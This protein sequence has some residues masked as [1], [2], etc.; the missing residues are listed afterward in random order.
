MKIQLFFGL[1]ILSASLLVSSAAAQ[2][3][4]ILSYGSEIEVQK[5]GEL[6]ITEKI[7]VNCQQVDIKRGIYRDFPT[8]YQDGSGHTISVD[9]KVLSV[10]RD[11]QSEKWHTESI[12][13]G[14][15]VYIGDAKVYLA[16]GIYS[17]EL[18]FKTNRQLGYFAD[19]DELYFNTVGTGWIFPIRYAYARITLPTEIKI[20]DYKAFTGPQEVRGSNYSAR[21]LASNIIQFETT[22]PLRAHEGLT[23][24]VSWPKGNISQSSPASPVF[25]GVAFALLLVIVLA[26]YYLVVWRKVGRDPKKGT[27]IP[28]YEAPEQ[29]EPAAVKYIMSM[30]YHNKCLLAAIS[31]LA[32]KGFIEISEHTEAKLGGLFDQTNILL[33]RKEGELSK[34]SDVENMIWT[35]LFANQDMIILKPS[36]E[37]HRIFYSVRRILKNTLRDNYKEKI[38]ALNY[39]YVIPPTIAALGLVGL[40]FALQSDSLPVVLALFLPLGAA[41]T[42]LFLYLLKTPTVEGRALMD[43]I[44][45][46]KMYLATAE[47]QD[48]A[49]AKA[50]NITTEMFEK[51]LPYAVALDVA[52]NWTKKFEASLIAQGKDFSHYH[53]GWHIGN[54]IWSSADFVDKAIGVNLSNAI[55][56]AGNAP[57]RSSGSGGSSGGG[58]G[59]GGGG[60]W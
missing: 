42:A 57:G 45:G 25:E 59:G 26:I 24:F 4:E 21:L 16:K 37:N 31:Q 52:S 56:A 5:N 3:E 46:Y 36:N 43:H 49:L 44:E 12:S 38:F 11:G 50:E 13:N 33:K 41:L 58:G 47:S 23:V 34:L 51:H 15:R 14:T 40:T 29:L 10:K 48:I 32:I 2:I 54:G 17:Y 28:Q 8:K 55:I 53:P 9:F 35:T 22:A 30:G 6:I 20:N 27:I 1:L 18:V 39:Q 7:K 60:G 19:H